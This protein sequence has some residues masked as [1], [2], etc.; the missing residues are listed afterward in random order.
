[1][2]DKEDNL[3]DDWATPEWQAEQIANAKNEEER[4]VMECVAYDCNGNFITKTYFK[5][6]VCRSLENHKKYVGISNI[7][8]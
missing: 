5:E 6:K 2:K 3:L 8:K 4:L 7:K 1:M